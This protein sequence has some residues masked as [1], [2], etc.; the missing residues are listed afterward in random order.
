VNDAIAIAVESPDQPGVMRLLEAGDALSRSLYPPES[1]HML[2]LDALLDPA[3]TFLVARRDG[4]VLGCAALVRKPDG[5]AEIKRMF[6][7]EASRGKGV[8]RRLL[9]R[10]E[11]IARAEGIAALKLETGIYQPAALALYRTAGY[12]EV[13]P[14][15]DYKP[16]PHSVF[17][18]KPLN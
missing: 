1:S 4:T 14:F 9:D 13:P 8:A 7:D 6:V 18:E 11:A 10:I 12:A 17:M 3:V 15:G 2:A 5:Y 16:D